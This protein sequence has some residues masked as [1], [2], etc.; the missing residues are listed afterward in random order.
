[1]LDIL[2]P[3]E[4]INGSLSLSDDPLLIRNS[5]VRAYLNVEQGERILSPEYG[6]ITKPQTSN[7]NAALI[8][9]LER[10]NAA[11]YFD[12]TF[13]VTANGRNMEIQVNA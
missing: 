1:M 3:L 10:L 7:V 2:F 13:T 4:A 5:Q 9:E 6:R 8:A 11:K 12:V